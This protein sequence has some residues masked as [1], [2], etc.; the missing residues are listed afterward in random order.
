MFEGLDDI[1]WAELTH[2]YGEASD[3]P[4]MLRG[5]VSLDP[6]E[7][8]HAMGTF[9]SAPLH[10]GS[11]YTATLASV[12][13]LIEAL[14]VAYTNREQLL[15]MLGA[16]GVGW[17]ESYTGQPKAL[18]DFNP[19][20]AVEHPGRRRHFDHDER[21]LSRDCYLVVAEG[22]P[23]YLALLA[24]PEQP[25]SLRSYAANLL[26]W[27][28]P[29]AFD[30]R[31]VLRALFA[32]GSASES[33]RA[34]AALALGHL[35]DPV[36]FT[37]QPSPLLDASVRLAAALHGSSEDRRALLG[38][39][40]REP[41]PEPDPP[42]P[43]G[44]LGEALGRVGGE[45]SELL[46]EYLASPT[47]TLRMLVMDRLFP[48]ERHPWMTTERP[49]RRIPDREVSSWSSMARRFL[50]S[51]AGEPDLWPTMGEMLRDRLGL[52]FEPTPAELT[53]T[54]EREPPR[55]GP[56][57]RE[58]QLSAEETTATIA[59]L[60]EGG[61]TQWDA[62]QSLDDVA[63]MPDA[64]VDPLLALAL[65]PDH[66]TAT[67]AAWLLGRADLKPAD[68]EQVLARV[69]R[70]PQANEHLSYLVGSLG[71]ALFDRTLD[72]IR[73][74]LDGDDWRIGGR[75]FPTV[76]AAGEGQIVGAL[77][78]D[79][80]GIRS[81][82]CFALQVHLRDG[83]H[84][85]PA[86]LESLLARRHD[87]D[88]GVRER[89]LW[90]LDGAGAAVLPL[91]EN[92]D[93][94][95]AEIVDLL[96]GLGSEVAQPDALRMVARQLE[97]ADWRV[98]VAAVDALGQGTPSPKWLE[99]LRVALRDPHEGPRQLAAAVAGRF[100]AE[101]API[102][103]AV[104]DAELPL[105]LALQTL[106]RLGSFAAA[107]PLLRAVAE[108]SPDPGL[109]RELHLTL[110]ALMPAALDLALERLDADPDVTA[111]QLWALAP[112]APIDHPRVT[113][114]AEEPSPAGAIARWL[115]ATPSSGSGP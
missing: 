78:D 65:G 88:E 69:M 76:A 30:A 10:Q 109:R 9:W 1:A 79:H 77:D 13:F 75:M 5:M 81:R 35:G 86:T 43:W 16:I 18:A 84:L 61:A 99:G 73:Y 11:V 53:E 24:D 104:V 68:G 105:P 74:L 70:D 58:R 25:E 98:R 6:D 59:A 33:L 80:P 89:A 8:E 39:L 26:A 46:D 48:P 62:M 41:I 108:A 91:L 90:A 85:E 82:A 55:P 60:A 57:R 38:P 51:L 101:A 47:E 64:L 110:H 31:R 95:A 29:P 111:V 4:S 71:P 40:H 56:R 52:V 44:S 22:C 23:Q 112:C 36:P 54:L 106:A 7:R 21:G 32:D 34:S 87:E 66:V 113:A 20:R 72:V 45:T 17:V 50:E 115:V 12:P 114:M 67:K 19:G 94:R 15:Q 83:G 97:H 102:A 103:S 93:R 107:E 2:A 96:H 37:R 100:G 42:W 92:P 49:V 14:S 3:V 27:F 63:R 28:P